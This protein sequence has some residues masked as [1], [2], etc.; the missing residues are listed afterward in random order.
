MTLA[1]KV[2]NASWN[3]SA[4]GLARKHALITRGSLTNKPSFTYS[5]HG[6]AQPTSVVAA[7]W[8]VP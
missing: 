1:R 2:P 5:T 8:R 3:M 6:R 7:K 4:V